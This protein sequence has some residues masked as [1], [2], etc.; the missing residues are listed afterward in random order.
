MNYKEN[1][2]LLK[3]STNESIIGSIDNDY[4]DFNYTQALRIYYPL[5]IEVIHKMRRDGPI[6]SINLSPWV[7]PISESAW[8]DLNP[9]QI[10]MSTLPSEGIEKY[11]NDCISRL[12]LSIK[13][14]ENLEDFKDEEPTDEELS[15]I[16]IEEAL[17]ELSDPFDSITIH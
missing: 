9:S 13:N 12:D 11:Y 14:S 10:V 6:E 17:D 8:V 3:L 5:K 4:E 2:I 15:D 7:D 16:E 1:L